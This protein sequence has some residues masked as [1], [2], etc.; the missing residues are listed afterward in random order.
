MQA[1]PNENTKFQYAHA[2][3]SSH[4]EE[5][6]F[7]V[8]KTSNLQTKESERTF[9]R[10]FQVFINADLRVILDESNELSTLTIRTEKTWTLYAHWDENNL[11]Q[12]RF[13][14]AKENYEQ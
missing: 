9:T 13:F 14:P 12:G 4:H 10:S 1:K 3:C 2:T 7:F 11:A 6:T 8:I 5:F